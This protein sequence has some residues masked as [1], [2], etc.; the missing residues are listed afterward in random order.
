VTRTCADRGCAW[1]GAGVAGRDGGENAGAAADAVVG[2]FSSVVLMTTGDT[3]GATGSGTDL[4]ATSS[5]EMLPSHAIRLA[6]ANPNTNEM[7]REVVS[8]A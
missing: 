3:D 6:K 7:T 5:P 4:A 1:T 2:N 8:M